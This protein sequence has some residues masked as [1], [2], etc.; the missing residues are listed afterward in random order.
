LAG[1]FA[2]SA[3]LTFN[4][5]TLTARDITDSSLT[6]GRVTYSGAAGNLAD[7]ANLTFDGTTMTMAANPVLSAGT[8]NGVLYLNGSKAATTGSALTFDG[9]TFWVAASSLNSDSLNVNGFRFGSGTFKQQFSAGFDF[10]QYYTA[11]GQASP[12]ASILV[13]TAAWGVK[14]T[15]TEQMRLT[16]TGLGIGTSS[17]GYKLDVNGAVNLPLG[18]WITGAGT[19]LVRATFFG[20]S[21]GYKVVQVGVTDSTSTGVALGVDVS[22]NP[23]GGFSGYEIVIPNNRAIIAPNAA[24]NGFVGVL[25]IGTDNN[26]YIGGNYSVPGNI[27]VNTTTGNTGIGTTS[28]NEKLSIGYADGSYGRIEFRSASYARQAVIEGVDDAASGSGHLSFYTRSGGNLNERFR[29]SNAG[30]WA[31][32]IVKSG[33]YTQ[34]Y[35]GTTNLP[36][37][38]GSLE[39]QEHFVILSTDSGCTGFSAI[40]SIATFYVRTEA[41]LNVI[42]NVARYGTMSYTLV[43]TNTYDVYLAV[44]AASLGWGCGGAKYATSNVYYTI[45]N[46]GRKGF[47]T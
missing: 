44:N 45:I 35:Y 18:T 36:F 34:D 41:N 31:S 3:N 40:L 37:D 46:S 9:S 30:H 28:P 12:Q 25:K 21:S 47:M 26:L 7:S 43:T 33:T 16:S 22:T 4:G 6:A 11:A 1:A 10:Q 15:G 5:T 42:H 13:D 32:N 38:F 14:I 29:L 2:G 24:N 8:A 27:F 23:N 19:K 20:Y 17:P 39:A